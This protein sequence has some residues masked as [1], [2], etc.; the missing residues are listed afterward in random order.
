MFRILGVIFVGFV[1]AICVF[2]LSFVFGG[3]LII[4]FICCGDYLPSWP[5]YVFI[6]IAV[7]VFIY[8]THS[9]WPKTK[10]K[11]G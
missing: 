9:L 7:V 8:V 6:A 3:A 4:K 10:N 1:A 11:T 2:L 5:G